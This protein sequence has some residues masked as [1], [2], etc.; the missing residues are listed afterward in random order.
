MKM[1]KGGFKLCLIGAGKM[2]KLMAKRAVASGFC[3]SE[4]I[5]FSIGRPMDRGK[6]K[7][8]LKM[9]PGCQIVDSNA[10]AIQGATIIIVAVRP[11]DLPDVGCDIKGKITNS[12]IV[13]SIVTGKSLAA[14]SEALDAKNIVRCCTNIALEIGF[15][16][17]LWKAAVGVSRESLTMVGEIFRNWGTSREIGKEAVL[18]V[19]MVAVGS[20]PALYL[21]IL[22]AVERGFVT[23]GMSHDDAKFCAMSVMGGTHELCRNRD[24]LA[25]S[26]IQKE[27]LTPGGITVDML[28]VMDRGALRAIIIDAIGAAVIKTLKLGQDK[29]GKS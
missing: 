9:F 15:A 29:G 11:D 17:T 10:E 8:L 23:H 1:I 3:K 25:W 14:L 21:E 27:V 2:A 28:L 26:E 24:G 4:Q 22:G 6:R 18:N 19:G 12:Q 13:V 20:L 16:T 5:C 7:Q